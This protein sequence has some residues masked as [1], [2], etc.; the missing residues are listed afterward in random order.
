M[1]VQKRWTSTPGFSVGTALQGV[2]PSAVGSVAQSCAQPVCDYPGSIFRPLWFVGDGRRAW[3][4]FLA[5][6]PMPAARAEATRAYR[7]ACGRLGRLE[8][9]E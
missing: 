8:L 6:K 5:R 3:I 9:E 4:C 1:T 2:H 7:V